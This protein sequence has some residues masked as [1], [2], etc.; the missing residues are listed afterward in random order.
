VS[1][2]LAAPPS[3]IWP[4]KLNVPAR[5]PKL[6]YLD[7]KDWINLSHVTT[8]GAHAKNFRDALDACRAARATGAAIFPIAAAHYMEMSG[9]GNPNKRKPIADLMEELSG[10]TTMLSRLVVVRLEFEE[11][12]TRRFGPSLE[13]FEPLSLLN[14]GVGPAF[15]VRGGLAIRDEDDRD[16]TDETRAQLGAA[17]FDALMQRMTRELERGVLAGPTDEEADELR[18][19]SAWD[20]AVARVGNQRRADQEQELRRHIDN[21]KWDRGVNLH[22]VVLAREAGI[23]L[24]PLLGEA[25]RRWGFSSVLELMSGKDAV[26]AF[27]R[28][29]PTCEVA[30][31]LKTQQHRANTK[32]WV[33][34][35][36]FDIDAMSAAVPYCDIVVT[37]ANRWHD[38]RQAKLDVRMGTVI[39]RSLSELPRHL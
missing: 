26:R 36:I 7:M 31:I 35:D 8:N 38:L 27:V 25:I 37:D 18:R 1:D 30:T 2:S 6:V 4:S 34:N 16:C 24:K 39:L 10:F 5:P 21:T 14:F 33:H 20:P 23:E 28:S 22:D 15:G 32:R 11:L 9:I 12:F 19:T 29:M 17:E 13:P 3:L